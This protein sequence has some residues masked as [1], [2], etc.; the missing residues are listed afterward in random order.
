MR[1]PLSE[2]H[3]A[4]DLVDDGLALGGGGSAKAQFPAEFV[5]ENER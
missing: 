3:D 1:G 4:T 2:C 5:R